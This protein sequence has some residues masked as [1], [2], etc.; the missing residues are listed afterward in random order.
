MTSNN[1][2]A[3]IWH[4]YNHPHFPSLTKYIKNLSKCKKIY[5][6]K[7]TML[8]IHFVGVKIAS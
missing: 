7:N 1:P 4:D 2:S 8:A 5:H 6:V 3:I